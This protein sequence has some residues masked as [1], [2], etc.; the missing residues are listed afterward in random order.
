MD[1]L[2][3]R[4]LAS[5]WKTRPETACLLAL[6]A[7]FL[8]HLIVRVNLSGALE[9]DEAEIVFMT[10]QLQPGYGAQPPLYAWLQWLTFS[11]FG[12]N[13]FSLAL[14]KNALLLATYASVL[15]IARPLLGPHGAIAAALSLCLFPQIVWESQR[16]LTHSVLLTTLAAATLCCYFA[17]LRKPVALRYALFGLLI[18]LGLQTKYN[19]GIFVVGLA[20]ASLLV[21][22]HRQALW[23]R[24]LAIAA[25]VALLVLLPH[26]LWLLSNLHAAS[27]GTLRKMAEG[28]QDAGYFGNVGTGLFSLVRGI[29]AFCA[30]ALLVLGLL[31]YR[32]RR[33]AGFAWQAPEAR[34]FVCL[35]GCFLVLLLGV[36]LTGEV[37]KIKDRWM[38]PLLFS[39]P[40]AFFVVLP[41]LPKKD[42][43]QWIARI[44]GGIGLAVLLLIPARSY[45]GPMLG[46]Y[47]ASHLP[48]SQLTD[49]LGRRFP[50]MTTVLTEGTLLAGNLHFYNPG[51][52]TVVLNGALKPRLEGDVLL[53]LQDDAKPGWRE[54]LRAAYPQAEIRE[55]GRIAL[56]RGADGGKTVSFDYVHLVLRSL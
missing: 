35:Y 12:L 11:L 48:F 15:F 29:L 34:F 36:V 41:A 4:R 55:Q 5:S 40:L 6:A 18:G 14:L 32:Y 39:L 49:E 31:R 20:G 27:S 21:A 53:V 52:R 56:N 2:T 22:P 54:R 43:S 8:L 23:N 46:K 44:A 37:G 42:V 50:Q 19:F 13:L 28:T 25:V 3:D 16:D 26:G 9:R 30:P 1:T 7:Y 24:K 38:L 10:Q 33:Q 47:A 45:L 51:L 17:L